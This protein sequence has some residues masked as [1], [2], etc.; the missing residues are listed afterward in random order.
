MRLARDIYFATRKLPDRLWNLYVCRPL[1][2]LFV[3]GLARTSV[4]PNQVTLASLVVAALSVAMLLTL[5]G[6]WGVVGAVVVYEISYILDCVD[7]MLARHRGVQ[8]QVGHWLDFLMDEIKAFALLAAVAYRL[9]ADLG[10]PDFLAVG[11]LGLVG[12]ASGVGLTTFL[13]RPEVSPA[14]GGA[15][16]TS[17]L[18]GVIS[19]IEAFAKFLVHYPSY[20]WLAALLG[21]LDFYLYP[22][23]AVNV[24]YASR[25]LLQVALRFGRSPRQ[26]AAARSDSGSD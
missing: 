2:A 10:R 8:S 21:R 17:G 13:R 1:A 22:Y 11:L 19:L 6:H 25:A 12:L 3:A 23:V 9:Y 24:L 15:A 4:T 5:P 18:R 14:T 7:G 26:S 16:P 20:I